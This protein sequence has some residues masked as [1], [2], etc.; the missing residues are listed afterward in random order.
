[1]PLGLPW[2]RRI[3]GFWRVLRLISFDPCQGGLRQKP[4]AGLTVALSGIIDARKD[5]L[6][7]GDEDSFGWHAAEYIGIYASAYKA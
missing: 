7:D 1:M 3:S 6:V 5:P 4:A 2:G